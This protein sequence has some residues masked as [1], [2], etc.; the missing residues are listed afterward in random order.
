MKLQTDKFVHKYEIP[1]QQEIDSVFSEL[2]PL[3]ERHN[4]PEW[5]KGYSRLDWS[6]QIDEVKKT[7]KGDAS[8]GVPYSMLSTKNGE[9][10]NK[11][12]ES[13]NCEVLDRI[14]RRLMYTREQ[15]QNVTP[16]ERV[17]LGLMDPV[18]VFVKN[19]PHKRS[20]L[21]EGRVRLI[22]SVS[23]VDKII[24]M[25][26]HRHLHKKEIKNWRTIPSKPGIGFTDDDVLSV[27]LDVDE[28]GKEM[29]YTDISGWDFNVKDWL[30]RVC[31]DGEIRLCD[32]P[33][34]VWV[35]LLE[36]EPI[37]E[38]QVVY[39]FSDGELVVLDFKGIVNSGKYKTSR[40]N[41]F[42]RAFLAF[43]VGARK[44]GAAGD[45]TYEEFVD[46][47]VEKYARY[48]FKIKDYQRVSNFFEFCSRIYTSDGSFPVNVDK[49]L[50]NFLHCS[51]KTNLERRMLLLQFTDN[52]K[53][54]PEF[55][56]VMK[57]VE[58]LG[59]MEDGESSI[60]FES[61]E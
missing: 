20:K 19:E 57:I 37:M 47:A 3:Y 55:P 33:S 44:V 34:A 24:E 36:L 41:S 35:R 23:L 17:Q 54:H 53:Y 39:Q 26:L 9:L 51:P 56:D 22:H 60:Y 43:L 1:S 25:L 7:I 16:V 42:M 14:E 2:L 61:M 30:M 15:I 12:G 31:K 32:N 59:M 58:D 38:S 5:L 11:L 50:M 29:V 10:M 18:R 21:N 28:S 13:L 6:R 4:L 45:D 8:P 52:L 46:D 49:M 48:G 27:W 40:G